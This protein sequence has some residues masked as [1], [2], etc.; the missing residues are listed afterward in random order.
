MNAEGVLQRVFAR[1]YSSTG[2]TG[3]SVAYVTAGV[4]NCAFTCD[5]TN[6]SVAFGAAAQIIDLSAVNSIEGVSSVYFKITFTGFNAGSNG[7]ARIDNVLVEGTLIP[8]PAAA[9]LLALVGLA[10]AR[11]RR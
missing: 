7:T 4:N 9:S 5:A 2:P 6:R 3:A 1:R 11:R 10:A 8:T